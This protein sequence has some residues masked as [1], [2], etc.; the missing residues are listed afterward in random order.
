MPMPTTFE[1]EPE[2]DDPSR[3]EARRELRGHAA[4]QQRPDRQRDQHR[5]RGERAQPERSLQVQRQ[6]E[7]QAELAERD[8]QRGDVAEAEAADREQPQVDHHQ[9]PGP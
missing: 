1:Q 4:R 9:L 6:H 7:Q 3:A 8:D 2:L 5:A